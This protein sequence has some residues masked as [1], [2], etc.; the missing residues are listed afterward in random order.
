MPPSDFPL[1][2]RTKLLAATMTLATLA[3]VVLLWLPGIPLGVPQ[4]WTWPRIPYTSA[5]IFAW[6]ASLA[7]AGCYIGFV[8]VVGRRLETIDSSTATKA[9]VER[10]AWMLG[11]V[12][13]AIGL[14]LS[15]LSSAPDILPVKNR[16][17]GNPEFIRVLFG[18]GRSPMVLYYGRTT[19]YF[20]EA[21]YSTVGSR[22]FLAT[23]ENW[24]T[25][26]SGMDRYLH[27]GT[28]PPG[29]ILMNRIVLAAADAFPG[30][31]AAIGST[32]PKSIRDMNEQIR[33]ESN[34]SG[35]EFTQRDA[36]CL[37]F[38]TL[39]TLVIAAATMAPLVGLLTRGGVRFSSAY[40]WASLWAL[41]PAV[42]VFL[43]KCDTLFPFPAM[44][45]GWLWL[46]SLDCGCRCRAFAAGLICFIGMSFSLVF[47]PIMV[48]LVVSTI[49]MW[50]SSPALSPRSSIPNLVFGFLGFALPIA[51]LWFATGLNLLNVW[52]LNLVNHAE[53]YQH[54]ARTYIA[55]LAANVV[56]IAI[57]V[58]PALAVLGLAG[59]WSALKEGLRSPVRMVAPVVGAATVLALLWLSG[60][61]MGEAAR[62]WI[63]F[64]P[65]FTLAAAIPIG[66]TSSTT[67]PSSPRYDSL[68]GLAAALQAL[69]TVLTSTRVDGFGF[70][71]LPL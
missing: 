33:V 53:F 28:H 52:R 2:V 59:A 30:V 17:P 32:A 21:R 13:A 43:P 37:W 15:L 5:H 20:F 24:L 49:V 45:A 63:P 62:L 40:R 10:A 57:A 60:K 46:T 65:W 29:M 51:A 67:D 8:F 58:G 35:R 70:S 27:L 44:L 48:W 66:A 47:A 11:L 64:L 22:E 42:C 25:E 31:A 36:A 71:E 69:A 9:R 38:V 41:T 34:V 1:N 39:F 56:E 4:E 26:Q 55:W 68:W 23:Y 14:W 54:N 50:R 3:A 6:L 18:L 19:G 16:K 7:P 61:N 12:V